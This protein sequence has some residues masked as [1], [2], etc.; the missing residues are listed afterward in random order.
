MR[1]VRRLFRGQGGYTLVELMLTM[2]ILAIVLV[3]L[4]SGWVSGTKSELNLNRLSQQ[5]ADVQL[6]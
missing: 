5:N 2:T 1:R 4:T 6:A 3:G